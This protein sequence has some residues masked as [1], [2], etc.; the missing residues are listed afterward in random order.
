MKSLA[1]A[2]G[3]VLAFTAAAVPYAKPST[4]VCGTIKSIG[5]FINSKNGQPFALGTLADGN[6]AVEIY[7]FKDEKVLVLVQYSRTDAQERG[8]EARSCSTFIGGVVVPE[9]S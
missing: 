3:I 4:E 6:T 5:A 1:L 8:G 9:R 2:L 7:H